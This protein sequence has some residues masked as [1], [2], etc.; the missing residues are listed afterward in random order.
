MERN[1]L[2]VSELK[3]LQSCEKHFLKLPRK[4]CS[5]CKRGSLSLMMM[6]I[7]KYVN[8]NDDL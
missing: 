7:E 2:D 1:K 5:D 8:K 6:V 3:T 4:Q